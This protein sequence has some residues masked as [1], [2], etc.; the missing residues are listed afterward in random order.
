MISDNHLV[1]HPWYFDPSLRLFYTP[2][3]ARLNKHSSEGTLAV[4]RELQFLGVPFR[5]SDPASSPFWFPPCA[6]SQQWGH[7]QP[8]RLSSCLPPYEPTMRPAQYHSALGC[9]TAWKSIPVGKIGSSTLPFRRKGDY[10]LG[11]LICQRCNIHHVRDLIA[12]V[13][14]LQSTRRDDIKRD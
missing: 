12:L 9:V 10:D 4:E 14:P 2:R 3:E 8:V 6:K 5:L 13:R 11:R 7:R 1:A